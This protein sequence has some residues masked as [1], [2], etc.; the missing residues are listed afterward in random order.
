MSKFKSPDQGQNHK[1]KV[2][3]V[4][5]PFTEVKIEGNWIHDSDSENTGLQSGIECTKHLAELNSGSP[6]L[7]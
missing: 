4:F 5:T 1:L 3:E 7:A 2:L 6:T